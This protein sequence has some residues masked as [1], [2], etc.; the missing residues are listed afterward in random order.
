MCNCNK[1]ELKYV[2]LSVLGT[3]KEREKEIML[4]RFGFLDDKEW[5][6]EEVGK[7]FNLTC[8]RIMQ[9]KAK[10]IRKLQNHCNAKK[11]VCFL[12]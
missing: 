2:I 6:L 3:L 5:T 10:S 9:I 8:E 4:L 12:E 11:L 7:K 1:K